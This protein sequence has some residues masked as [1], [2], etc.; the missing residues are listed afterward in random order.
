MT[1]RNTGANN[2]SPWYLKHTAGLFPHA[3]GRLHTQSES[4]HDKLFVIE[5]TAVLGD[6]WAKR[7]TYFQ[8]IF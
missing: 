4:T 2:A 7:F 5:T 8:V 1:A 3:A 6:L